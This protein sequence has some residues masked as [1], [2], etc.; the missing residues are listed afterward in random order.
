MELLS[1]NGLGNLAARSYTC[2]Y[3]GT[4]IASEKGWHAT[5]RGLNNIGAYIYVCHKCSR[6]TLIDETDGSQTPGVVFG[7]EVS[8]IPEKE[9]HD[10]YNE[11]RKCTGASAYTAAIL[12]CRKLLMH[13][14][15]SK[16]ADDNKSFAYYVGYLADNHFVPPDAKGWVDHIRK[17][18]NEANHEISIMQ[19]DDAEE[20]LSFLEM[21]LK[22]IY[23]FPST[24]ASKYIT[25]DTST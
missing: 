22:V 9:I 6:P 13:I 8:G 11:A 10:L 17:K 4:P 15:V 21:L 23:E 16:G 7:S 5:R 19:Q 14:A 12:C 2:G 20:L 24:V 3:C 25:D 1:W 18:G